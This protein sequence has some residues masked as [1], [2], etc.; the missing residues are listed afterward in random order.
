M[1]SDLR[2]GRSAAHRLLEQGQA[3][4]WIFAAFGT[5]IAFTH[6]ATKSAGPLATFTI[7]LNCA[8]TSSIAVET[9]G[10]P[11]AMYSSALVGLINSVASFSANG[12]KQT[13]NPFA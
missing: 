3:P 8:T 4:R 6:F 2:V 7:L 11:V 5:V 13:S 12:I 1:G 9:M 10:V